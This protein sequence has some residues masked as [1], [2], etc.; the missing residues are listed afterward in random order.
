[1]PQ[2]KIICQHC[3]GIFSVGGFDFPDRESLEDSD[4]L[5]VRS[6]CPLC[7]KENIWNKNDVVNTLEFSRKQLVVP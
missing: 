1:M 3:G 2:P 4:L 7:E 6:F 5:D